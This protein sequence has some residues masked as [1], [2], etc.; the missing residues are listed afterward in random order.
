MK[1]VLSWLGLGCSRPLWTPLWK[2]E[3]LQ[4]GDPS[5]SSC[6]NMVSNPPPLE[7]T[8]KFVCLHA[9][10]S[11]RASGLRH[12]SKWVFLS[13]DAVVSTSLLPHPTVLLPRAHRTVLS[14]TASPGMGVNYLQSLWESHFSSFSLLLTRTLLTPTTYSLTTV[15]EEGHERAPGWHRQRGTSQKSWQWEQVKWL[16]HGVKIGH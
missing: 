13:I 7:V 11:T 16:L 12:P 14:L 10:G 5:V 4:G 6:W 1:L 2:P 15:S 3:E 9:K 8:A